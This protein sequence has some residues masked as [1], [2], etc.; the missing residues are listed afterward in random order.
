MVNTAHTQSEQNVFERQR[1][2][3][4]GQQPRRGVW[5]DNPTP[6][7]ARTATPCVARI[8]LGAILIGGHQR[9]AFPIIGLLCIQATR[10]IIAVRVPTAIDF[11]RIRLFHDLAQQIVLR[12]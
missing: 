8:L 2:T 6:H 12:P 1:H 11:C 7:A 5:Q 3:T 9:A 4:N 10:C